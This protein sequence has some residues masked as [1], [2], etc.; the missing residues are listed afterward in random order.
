MSFDIIVASDYGQI[1]KITFID[2][3]TDAAADIS[4]YSSTI[5]MIF[6]SPSGTSTT[7]TATFDSDGTD[8]VIKYTIE[9]SFLTTA[10]NWKVR[11]RVASGSA[12]LTTEQHTFRVLE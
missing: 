1:A 10:G 11:G 7:K 2:V 9:Q 3:D 8:G 5:S 6:T 4:S 12:V